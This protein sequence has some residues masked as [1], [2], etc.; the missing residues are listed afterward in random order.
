MIKGRQIPASSRACGSDGSEPDAKPMTIKL[1]INGSD[2]NG[3]DACC[4]SESG[5]ALEAG[6]SSLEEQNNSSS[7]QQQSSYF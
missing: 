7:V 2:H 5:G 3:D 4:E 6:E 1:M